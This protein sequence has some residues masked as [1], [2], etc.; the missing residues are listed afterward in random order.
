[1]GFEFDYMLLVHENDGHNGGSACVTEQPSWRAFAGSDESFE[2][3]HSCLLV[4]GAYCEVASIWLATCI[5][6]GGSSRLCAQP[7]LACL[8][9]AASLG[10]PRSLHAL[11]LREYVKQGNILVL[12]IAT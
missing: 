4:T 6:Q 9:Q 7:A 12:E 11:Q 5:S 1:M 10:P 2:E 3:C 8:L